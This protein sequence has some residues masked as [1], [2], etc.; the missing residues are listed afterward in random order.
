MGV[1]LL[2]IATCKRC[3]KLFQSTIT[4]LCPNC[5]RKDEAV[6]D[7]IKIYLRANQNANI[8]DIVKALDVDEEL[9]FK[10]LREGRLIATN[11]MS[12]PCTGCGKPIASG[13]YC[14]NC[15]KNLVGKVNNLKESIRKESGKNKSGYFSK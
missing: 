2:T 9:V 10:F 4:E 11:K 5:V 15:L 13:K 1:D 12:Y 8:A 3:G 6:F 7:E 14:P